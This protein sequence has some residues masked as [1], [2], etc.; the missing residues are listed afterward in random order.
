MILSVWGEERRMEEVRRLTRHRHT[1]VPI[2]QLMAL[3]LSLLDALIL[4]MQGVQGEKGDYMDRAH[5]PVPK[6][7]WECLREDCRIFSGRPTRFLESLSQP[8]SY[9][10]SDE[11]CGADRTGNA[12]LCTGSHEPHPV[13]MQCGH[14]R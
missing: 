3:D 4:P 6:T 13:K 11:R 14:H 7:F 2:S 9:Y 10:L 8:K 1:C 12:V 5:I